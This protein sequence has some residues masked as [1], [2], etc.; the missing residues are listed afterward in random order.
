MRF[1]DSTNETG[2]V[3]EIRFLT[4]AN[5]GDFTDKDITRS[6]NLALDTYFDIAMASN[7]RWDIDDI[8]HSDYA[9]ATAT[10]T[11]GQA[12]YQMPSE[13]IEIK[14]VTIK[15]SDGNWHT[16]KPVDEMDVDQPLEELYKTD[17]TPEYY[18]KRNGSLFLY[19][20]PN[21]TQAASIKVHYTRVA[22]YFLYTDTTKQAGIPRHH[23]DF[24][25]L[26]ATNRYGMKH[27]L[28]NGEKIKRELEESKQMVSDYWANLGLDR[29]PRMGAV[30]V[31]GR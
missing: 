18:D 2:I 5:S 1:N 22:N 6:V 8:T 30:R 23:H 20:A 4:G 7:S 17:G 15:N 12:D 24:L 26:F 13:L 19:P 31:S 27:T 3:Q 29:Q 25:V 16:L 10:L 11:S 14:K 21:Y 9:E 28:Q